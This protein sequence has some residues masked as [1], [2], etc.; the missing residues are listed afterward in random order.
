MPT[1]GSYGSLL[2]RL[3]LITGGGSG[4]GASIVE[5]FVQQGIGAEADRRSPGTVARLNFDGVERGS[6]IAAEARSPADSPKPEHSLKDRF[7]P[8]L[9]ATFSAGMTIR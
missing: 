6:L 8:V 5:Q 9:L 7:F 3:V 4:I 2:D 1:Y